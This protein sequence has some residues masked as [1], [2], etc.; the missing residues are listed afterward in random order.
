MAKEVPLKGHFT[1]SILIRFK[2]IICKAFRKLYSHLLP[3]FI[4]K[5]L[6]WS[7]LLFWRI[8][9]E[10]NGDAAW[11]ITMNRSIKGFF[12]N[13]LL[14]WESYDGAAAS[15]KAL[16]FCSLNNDVRIFLTVLLYRHHY[17]WQPL[18]FSLYSLKLRGRL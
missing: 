18:N 15:Q 8:E 17:R 12:K 5:W 13:Q 10:I 6:L 2:V 16:H 7:L 9:P 1:V 4:W 3:K 11:N 14:Q